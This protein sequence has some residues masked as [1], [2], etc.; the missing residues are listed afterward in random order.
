MSFWN[1]FGKRSLTASLRF[2]RLKR[3]SKGARNTGGPCAST[4]SSFA[5]A[6]VLPVASLAK[7]QYYLEM[8][9]FRSAWDRSLTARRR[10]WSRSAFHDRPHRTDRFIQCYGGKRF[11]SCPN[12]RSH[13]GPHDLTGTATTRAEGLHRLLV[14]TMELWCYPTNRAAPRNPSMSKSKKSSQTTSLV[15]RITETAQNHQQKGKA[16]YET[17]HRI[18]SARPSSWPE[19]SSPAWRWPMRRRRN[20]TPPW[21]R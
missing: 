1:L 13:L 6:R 15:R 10:L 7:C 21:R 17:Q 19:R 9:D 4:F 11:H 14:R 16:Y 18:T 8:L 12:H 2:G 20:S 3:R 5:A